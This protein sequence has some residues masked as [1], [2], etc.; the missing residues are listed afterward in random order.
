MRLCYTELV[1]QSLFDARELPLLELWLQDLSE[2]RKALP[3]AQ[4]P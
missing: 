2:I 4:R 3:D 1:R